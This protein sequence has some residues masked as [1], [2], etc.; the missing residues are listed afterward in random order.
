MKRLIFI[1]LAGIF[2]FAGLNCRRET[3]TKWG[4][5]NFKVFLYKP[6]ADMV[7][8]NINVTIF[9]NGERI[10]DAVTDSL[11][12]ASF[13]L[14]DGHYSVIAEDNGSNSYFSSDKSKCYI[15]TSRASGPQEFDIVE[16]NE[17]NV[18]VI[19]DN[20]IPL[21]APGLLEVIVMKK[22]VPFPKV[23]VTLYKTLDDALNLRTDTNTPYLLSDSKGLASYPVEPGNYYMVANWRDK[24]G[25]LYT[26]D[27]SRT[28][29]R[30]PFTDANGPKLV[31]IKDRLHLTSDTAIID[32]GK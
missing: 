12:E 18:V 1:S 29:N 22:G 2:L 13:T 3:M 31:V 14:P 26:S 16:G 7:K 21:I 5:V 27:T 30:P 8:S 17:F 4:R 15:D 6:D 9:H 23:Q 25:V 19:L 28:K 10:A 24:S 11:G 20:A 32:E